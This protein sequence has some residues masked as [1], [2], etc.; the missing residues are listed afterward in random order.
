MRKFFPS[1]TYIQMQELAFAN[2]F[3]NVPPDTT[4]ISSE[5]ENQD[6]N[7][8]GLRHEEVVPENGMTPIQERQES[9]LDLQPASTPGI[10]PASSV[11]AASAPGPV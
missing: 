10:V 6:Q 9:A 7:S 11:R 1:P 2:R 5:C 4:N 3:I 8:A